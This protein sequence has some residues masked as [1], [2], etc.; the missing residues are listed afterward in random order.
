MIFTPVVF[1]T[2]SDKWFNKEFNEKRSLHKYDTREGI[3]IDIY[4]KDYFGGKEKRRH[5]K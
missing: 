1:D 2:V 4:H 5:F 3:M